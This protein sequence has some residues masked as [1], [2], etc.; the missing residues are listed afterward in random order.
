MSRLQLDVNI[1]KRKISAAFRKAIVSDL[2]LWFSH[3]ISAY[4][5]RSQMPN[6][7][8]FR[9]R[10]LCQCVL[11][12]SQRTPEAE[13][14]SGDIGSVCIVDSPPAKGQTCPLLKRIIR[15]PIVQLH[16]HELKFHK[17]YI[18]IYQIS[19]ASS[20]IKMRVSFDLCDSLD[21]QG[22]TESAFQDCLKGQC[23]TLPAGQP[24]QDRLSRTRFQVV[25][26]SMS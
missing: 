15:N 11:R 20:T 19:T 23:V 9:Q 21:F 12:G 18:E 6:N 5:F 17:T 3:S 2:E 7:T 22:Q 8:R 24:H 14:H 10:N 25:S 1:K 16:S 26:G 13:R 4:F